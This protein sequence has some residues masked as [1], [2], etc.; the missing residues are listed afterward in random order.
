MQIR[1]ILAVSNAKAAD[2]SFFAPLPPTRTSTLSS[3]IS[4]ALA[5]TTP[6]NVARL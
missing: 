2:K 4:I 6:V 1:V 3:M 5:G